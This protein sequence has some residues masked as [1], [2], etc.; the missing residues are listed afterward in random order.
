IIKKNYANN[1]IEYYPNFFN[2]IKKIYKTKYKKIN[3][4]LYTYSND[5]S[6]INLNN[7]RIEIISIHQANLIDNIEIIYNKYIDIS[8]IIKYIKL[9]EDFLF[10][11][12]NYILNI[13][14]KMKSSKIIINEEL[15]NDV[16]KYFKLIFIDIK[17]LKCKNISNLENN[18]MV[19]SIV[20]LNEI[21]IN[22]LEKKINDNL[23][24]H[25]NFK[26]SLIDKLKNFIILNK[27]NLKK[28]FSIFIFGKSGIGKTE[29]ARL[30]AEFIKEKSTFIKIN[31]GNYSSKD[32][33]NSL[34]GSPRG[35]IGSET[36]ELSIK[37]NNANVGIIL[38]DEF[39]KADSK[40]FNFFLELLEDGKFTD[41]QS[42]EY[43]LN[44]YIIIFTS[45]IE[46]ENQYNNIIPNTLTTRFDMIFHFTIPR[47]NDK[48]KFI[49]L[50]C[51][52]LI[53]RENLKALNIS[54]I[55]D[56]DIKKL[57]LYEYDNIESLR[58]IEL[59]LKNKFIDI[60][61]SYTNINKKNN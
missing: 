34:I 11:A 15:T 44:K 29:V 23:I 48:E 39:E 46:N 18:V 7:K 30:L 56:D 22:D 21:E 20:D 60:I 42:K 33:L 10:L 38:C 51:N 61:K 31:F 50:V 17:K 35:F 54:N 19:K 55:S 14:N 13:I 6:N 1:A 26:H 52:K 45:N 59:I 2:K 24:G 36:G 12:E 5:I 27:M 40:I 58:D 16:I 9:Q 47:K 53:K 43:D 49:E 3:T 28:V 32:A 37:L 25:D 8:N 41:S 57:K 4:T